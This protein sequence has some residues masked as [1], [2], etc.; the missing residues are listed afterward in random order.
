MLGTLSRRQST[1][2]VLFLMNAAQLVIFSTLS[3][4]GTER[5]QL[6]PSSLSTAALFAHGTAVFAFAIVLMAVSGYMTQASLSQATRHG[7]A[8]QISALDTLRIPALACA[9]ALLFGEPLE[10]AVIIPGAVIMCGAILTAY[11]DRTR[12]CKTRAA[13]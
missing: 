2:S 13:G 4:I 8:V 11:L 9:G 1:R 3:M 10:Q 6:P 7:T 12:Q 5:L